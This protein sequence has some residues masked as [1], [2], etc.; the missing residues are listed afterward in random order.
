[1]WCV[2]GC[3]CLACCVYRRGYTRVDA[4]ACASVGPPERTCVLGGKLDLGDSLLNLENPRSQLTRTT[5]TETASLI[6]SV[7]GLA[8]PT[9]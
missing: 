2:I 1:M 3:W 8:A 4:D 5:S 6:S 9:G 7:M